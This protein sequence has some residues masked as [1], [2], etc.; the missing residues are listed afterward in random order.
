M[1]VA[2]FMPGLAAF[3][4]SFVSPEFAPLA[5]P[6]LIGGGVL[7]LLM[8]IKHK[9]AAHPTVSHLSPDPE[10]RRPIDRRQGLGAGV[11]V[12]HGLQKVQGRPGTVGSDER[13]GS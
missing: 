10:K 3:L 6:S 7:A 13:N 9:R 2:V 4:L 5:W 8:G 12:Q 11:Q 1:S